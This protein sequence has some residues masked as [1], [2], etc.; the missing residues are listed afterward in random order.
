MTKTVVVPEQKPLMIQ[1]LALSVAMARRAGEIIRDITL[2]GK[3]QVVYKVGIT[4]Y[5]IKKNIF[6]N[7]IICT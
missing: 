2:N 3:M 7:I 1:L 6:A 4:F 5:I